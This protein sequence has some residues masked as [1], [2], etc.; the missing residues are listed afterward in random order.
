MYM[1]GTPWLTLRAV[2]AGELSLAWRRRTLRIDGDAWLA[3]GATEPATSHGESS[4]AG[5]L[6]VTLDAED[7]SE[8]L[9]GSS[10][11]AAATGFIGHLLPMDAAAAECWR[12][13]ADARLAG[14]RCDDAVRLDGLELVAGAARTYAALRRRADGFGCA[15]PA[16]RDSLLEK[17]LTAADF[18]A[19]HYDEPIRL[20]EMAQAAGLSRFHFVRLFRVVHGETPHAWLVR[21]RA[22]VARRRL[23]SGDDIAEAAT[24][25]GF[26]SRSALFRNLR[27]WPPI[28]AIEPCCRSA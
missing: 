6:S 26:G 24:H 18:I 8:R 11:D 28:G 12:R 3:V 5:L 14:H 9:D 10:L 13:I 7:T 4:A 21:K 20:A 1:H 22:R 17:I 15:R 2:T 27:K 16:T 25:A 23:A 19:S